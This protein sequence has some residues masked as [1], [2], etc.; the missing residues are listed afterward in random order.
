VFL[1]ANSTPQKDD[2]NHQP[3]GSP[4]ACKDPPP[5]LQNMPFDPMAFLKEWGEKMQMMHQHQP[6][7]IIVESRAD[8]SCES[9]AKFNN[10]IRQLL[11]IA[12]DVNFVPP[13]SFGVPWIP[14]YMQAMLNILA[15]PLTVRASHMVNILTTCFSQVPT[16]IG[17]HLSPLT[18]H[19]S[20]QHI[21]MNFALALLS[22]NV[23]RTPLDSLKF[24]TRLISF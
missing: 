9:K 5:P 18:T 8:K 2:T 4:A 1:P 12:S 7:T 16:D 3:L 24:E 17:K 11:L 23:Q 13:G 22:A 10:H 19:K 15:Q 20:M 21:S 14:V 6:Q